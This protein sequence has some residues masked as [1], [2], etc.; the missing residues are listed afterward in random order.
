M[1]LSGQ[2]A[3]I[4]GSGLEKK[5]SIGPKY[6]GLVIQH[7][8]NFTHF[9]TYQEMQFSFFAPFP[10]VSLECFPVRLW[11]PGSFFNFC[12]YFKKE[13][14]R[15]KTH[16][17]TDKLMHVREKARYRDYKVL[18]VPRTSVLCIPPLVFVPDKIHFWVSY[19]QQAR[20]KSLQGCFPSAPA[21]FAKCQGLT[22]DAIIYYQLI[23]QPEF[24]LLLL[25]LF[26][27]I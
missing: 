7:S 4:I 9:E 19:Q 23:T 1:W 11:L 18:F 27:L 14:K 26:L 16:I 8:R 21:I 6:T 24:S 10:S 25:L 5:E 20:S 15:K 2:C 17:H 22:F 3:R 13:E 12:T